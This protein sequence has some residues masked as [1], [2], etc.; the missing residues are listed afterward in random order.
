VRVPGYPQLP[1][2]ESP[3]STPA[4]GHRGSKYDFHGM[5]IVDQAGD[6][7]YYG[8]AGHDD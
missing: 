1:S 5:A 7:H 6:R 8:G 3:K 4:P 2:R